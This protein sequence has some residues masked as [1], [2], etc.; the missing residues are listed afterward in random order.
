VENCQLG[1]F[2]SDASRLGAAFLDRELY[3]PQVWTDDRAC[4]QHAGIPEDRRLATKPQLAQQ[5]LA[6]AFAAGVPATWVTGDSIIGGRLS[7]G[8]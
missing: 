3:L 5:L 7:L 1:V 4:C 8:R 2:L 6:R